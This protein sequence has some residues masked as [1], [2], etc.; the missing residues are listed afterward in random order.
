M[1]KRI[2]KFKDGQYGIRRWLFGFEYLDLSNR[3]TWRRSTSLYFDNCK[4]SFKKAVI[5][6][7]K[8]RLLS[9]KEIEQ[10]QIV[11]ALKSD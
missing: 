2:V 1:V 8:G 4:G 7:D 10:T 6:I 3:C 9:K 11:N 5:V